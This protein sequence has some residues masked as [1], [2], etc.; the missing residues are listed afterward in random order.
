MAVWL[1]GGKL[2]VR[3]NAET[4]WVWSLLSTERVRVTVCWQGAVI[5]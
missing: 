1:H 5:F 4:L 3:L 2:V